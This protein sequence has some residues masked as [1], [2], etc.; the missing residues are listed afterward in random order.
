MKP[1]TLSVASI[2]PLLFLPVAAAAAPQE[3]TSA[4]VNA[5]DTAWVMVCSA[6]V[7]LMTIPGLALF[8]GGLVHTKNVLATLMQSFIIA[9]LISIQW[10]C[11]RLQPGLLPG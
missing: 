7:L 11:D 9:A 1:R 3:A 2:I 4:T 5:G 10:G 6:L 8:Y